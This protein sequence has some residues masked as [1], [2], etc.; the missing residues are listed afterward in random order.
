M[1]RQTNSEL[2]R[3]GYSSD[4]AYSVLKV[5]SL[6]VAS[7][8]EGLLRHALKTFVLRLSLLTSSGKGT[9]GLLV[10]LPLK[11]LLTSKGALCGL[12]IRIEHNKSSLDESDQS[13][14]TIDQGPHDLL[15]GRLTRAE[16][17][18]PDGA[19]DDAYT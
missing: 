19:F 1:R 11:L 13:V 10:S 15:A 8:F 3:L 18:E 17:W 2:D 6:F 16:R 7:L 9:H 5:T 14:R 12:L 4:F